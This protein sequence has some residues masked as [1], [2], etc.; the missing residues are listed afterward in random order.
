MTGAA[1][2][3]T[4]TGPS[5]AATERATALAVSAIV[6]RGSRFLLV[7][8]AN[9]PAADMYAFPGGRVEPDETLEM[10]VL[11]ELA[12]ET[13]IAGA[14]PRVFETYDLSADDPKG[15]HFVLTVFTVEETDEIDVVALDDAAAV[16]WFTVGEARRLP[17][18]P[19]MHDCFDRL[20][21]GAAW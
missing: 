21:A 8:R 14:N 18:P 20:E 12:E 2:T 17:M 7:L 15:R 6:R 19:S 11:R 16:G 3:T 4:A 10:A 13:G 5:A 1:A 9:P